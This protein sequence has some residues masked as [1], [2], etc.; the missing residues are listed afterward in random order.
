MR[1]MIILKKSRIVCIYRD[2]KGQKVF[3][4]SEKKILKRIQEHIHLSENIY[5][6]LALELDISE[7]RLLSELKKLARRNIIRNISAIFNADS[8]GYHSILTACQV[9]AQLLE[10]AAAK[11]NKHPGVSHNYQRNHLYNLW[12]TLTLPIVLDLSSEII[13]IMNDL[14]IKNFILFPAQKKIKVKVALPF[15]F[16][17]L[18]NV[19]KEKSL[20]RS[21]AAK[22]KISPKNII[23][24]EKQKKIIRFLLLDLPF[25]KKPLQKLLQS[26]NLD[27]EVKDIIEEAG[28]LYAN[29]IM[30]RY[31]AVLRQNQSGYKNNALVVWKAE[32]EQ[33]LLLKKISIEIPEISHVYFRGAQGDKWEY[34]L[35]TMIHARGNEELNFIINKFKDLSGLDEYLVLETLKEFKKQ[36]VCYFSDYFKKREREVLNDRY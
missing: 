30:R 5:A 14:K 33:E 11:I 35:F 7:D 32:P 15:L 6:D 24:N 36:L 2:L 19:E 21:L 18:S 20:S 16:P 22:I 8:L 12:F 23:F 26:N 10:N 9:D 3:N 28:Y 34:P 27:L 31:S 4:K 13:S 29:N 1:I 17:S 25:E